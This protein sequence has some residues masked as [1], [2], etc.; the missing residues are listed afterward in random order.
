[1]RHLRGLTLTPDPDSNP[2]P[3]PIPD[4]NPPAALHVL[5][6]PCE[7]PAWAEWA[8]AAH[9]TITAT[10][11]I[12]ITITAALH[13]LEHSGEAP[14]WTAHT[15]ITIALT[16]TLILTHLQRFMCWSTLVRHLR[17]LSGREQLTGPIEW[18]KVDVEGAEKNLF[19]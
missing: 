17:G 10:L 2:N 11:T 8:G 12:T 13:A 15:T 6:Y 5:E 16:L 1:M 4:P 9:I 7:V 18:L 3:N 19:W 14:A